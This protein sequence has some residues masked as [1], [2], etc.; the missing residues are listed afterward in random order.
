M[1]SPETPFIVVICHD[2]YRTPEPYQPFLT[3]PKAQNIEPYRPPL[4]SSDFRRI[5]VGDVTNPHYN[6]DPPYPQ[7][8]DD[9]AV[10]NE[11]LSQLILRSGKRVLLVGHSYLL[12]V[13]VLDPNGR[14]RTQLL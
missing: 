3:A 7:P 10:L 5:N 9:A 4:P 6:N 2:S 1:S 13:R 14:V 12:R 8:A 11:L